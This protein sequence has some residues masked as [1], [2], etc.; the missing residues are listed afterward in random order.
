MSVIRIQ[1]RHGLNGEIH[2]QGS[3][4]GV[5]PIMAG[6]LLHRGTTVITT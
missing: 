4:N 1:G 6:A 5:L 2:I 3:K